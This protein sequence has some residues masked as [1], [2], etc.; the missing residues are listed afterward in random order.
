VVLALGLALTVAPLSTAVLAAVEDRHKGLGSGVNNAASRVAGLLAVALLPAVAGFASSGSASGAA[1]A[2]GF[3][4][5]MW[6]CTGLCWLG[7]LVS[8]AT[9]RRSVPLRQALHPSLQQACCDPALQEP[10]VAAR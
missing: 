7:G 6:I 4:R 1:F 10:E 5:V 3:R 2:T 9:I 8:L